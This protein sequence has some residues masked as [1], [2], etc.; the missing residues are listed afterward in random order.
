MIPLSIDAIREV[1]KYDPLTGIFTWK[2]T[3][4]RRAKGTVAGTYH[5]AGAVFIKIGCKNYAAHRL[6]YALVHGYMPKRVK[7]YNLNN[8][9]N[10]IANLYACEEPVD[11]RVRAVRPAVSSRY[12]DNLLNQSWVS[13]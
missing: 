3:V 7:H 4:N 2:Q 5:P 9:D 13:L 10:R 6:A 1:L 11:K 8:Y 12:P